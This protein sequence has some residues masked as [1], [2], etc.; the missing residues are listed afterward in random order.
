MPSPKRLVPTLFQA[1]AYDAYIKHGNQMDA[2]RALGRHQGSVRNDI[3]RYCEI[4]GTP[5]P[6]GIRGSR[7]PP[8]AAQI[9]AQVP[10]RLD[11]QEERLAAIEGDL[12]RLTLLV[13][14]FVGRQPV[15]L[16]V[17]PTHRRK[18]DGGV[19][20]RNEHRALPRVVGG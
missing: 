19:G 12:R 3:M 20:G 16:G 13:E 5:L 17:G 1:A 4:T 10:P 2:S 14:S 7:R 15:I 18:A 6:D 11:A 9:M 8:S